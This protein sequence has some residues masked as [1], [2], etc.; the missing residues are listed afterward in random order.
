VQIGPVDYYTVSLINDA[1]ADASRTGSSR[2]KT[3]TANTPIANMTEATM[4][5]ERRPHHAVAVAPS[6]GPM[7]FAPEIA[8]AVGHLEAIPY[9]TLHIATE[10]K[11]VY[12]LA[13]RSRPNVR[14]GRRADLPVQLPADTSLNIDRWRA[15]KESW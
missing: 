3:T 13:R 12:D 10:R 6:T 11:S 15:L 1:Y 5:G 4:K 9:Q 7:A 8:L 14:P 2:M